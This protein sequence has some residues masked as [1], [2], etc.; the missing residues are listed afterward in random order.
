M[1]KKVVNAYYAHRSN[2][3]ELLQ[4]IPEDDRES[5]IALLTR[6]AE[7]DFAIVK[8]DK[9]NV[10]LISSPDWDEANEPLVGRCYRWKVGHW[11]E[12]PVVRDNFK[13]IYHCKY[14]F[15][16]V[17]YDGFDINQAK[18][19]AKQWNAIPNLNKGKI[20]YKSYW[21]EL[22]KENGMEV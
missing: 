4:H 19:R 16:A 9:G 20:G 6:E 18:E 8:Y 7:R 12:A 17:D 5:L 11:D 3:N 2:I 21:V 14:M 22:L 15:V 1:V 10:T 13:Q